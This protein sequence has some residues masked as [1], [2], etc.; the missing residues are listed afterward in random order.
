MEDK[1]NIDNHPV[2]ESQEEEKEIDLLELASK[3]WKGRRFIIKWSVIGAVVGLI[4]AFSIPKEYATSVKLAPE[5]TGG[6]SAGGGLGALAAMAGINTGSGSADAVYPQLYPDVVGSV[7]FA[8]SLFDVP[9]TDVKKEHKYTV[10][11]YLEEETKAPWWSAV[12]G[13]PF[14]LIGLLRSSDDSDKNKSNKIDEFQLTPKEDAVM[15]ALNQR[16]SASVD[17][18]TNVVTISVSMQDPMVSAILADTVVDRLQKYVTEY[19]TNK[20]R[21]DLEYAEKLNNEAKEAYYKSQ[22]RYADYLDR[23]Q[24]LVM[25]SAQTTRDRLENEA[26]LA[27]NLYN[28]TS[29]QLQIAKAKVQENTPVYATVSPATV[30]LKAASPKKPLILIAFTFLGFLGSAAW[31]LFIKPIIKEAKAKKEKED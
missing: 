19:R 13:L 6:K 21:K 2:A 28:Q 27:F 17:A 7:P 22:Q 24:G 18:K 15:K 9:V 26:T 4:V 23:N 5:A 25:H 30:P 14:K 20:A 29:Q 16:I 31:L 8:V 10:R 3:L 1:N 11:Q 12:T